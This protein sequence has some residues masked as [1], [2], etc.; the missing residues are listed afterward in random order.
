MC[1]ESLKILRMRR[2][3]KICAAF[4]MYS[5]EYWE[6]SWLRMS[7]RKKG[8]IPRRSIMLRK[9]SMKLNWKKE[10]QLQMVGTN[11][12]Y[13]NLWRR[14]DKSY[15]KLQG[16][17]ADKN[18]FRHAEEEVLFLLAIFWHFLETRKSMTVST[19]ED[20]IRGYYKIQKA[21]VYRPLME[22]AALNWFSGYRSRIKWKQGQKG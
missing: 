18:G 4:A 22:L 17:P 6:E 10:I 1:R 8:R 9:D 13:T 11:R 12:V 19:M 21:D 3:R 5:R 14:N 7:E 16:E 20:S 2:I 15:H